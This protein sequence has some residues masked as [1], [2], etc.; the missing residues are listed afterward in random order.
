MW[1]LLY[2]Y[3]LAYTLSLWC[4]LLQV[5]GIGR[6]AGPRSQLPVNWLTDESLHRLAAQHNMTVIQS[7][8]PPTQQG[9]STSSAPAQVHTL[10]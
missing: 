8:H 6:N 1:L 3:S 10:H 9:G 7:R 2:I 4:G 5:L